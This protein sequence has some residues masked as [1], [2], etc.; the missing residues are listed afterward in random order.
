MAKD[1]ASRAHKKKR[2]QGGQKK[3]KKGGA[4]SSSPKQ[5]RGQTKSR[6]TQAQTKPFPW[7]AVFGLIIIIALLVG[8]VCYF[9]AHSRE[10]T[11]R[12]VPIETVQ[13]AHAARSAPEAA[14]LMNRAVDFVFQP[15][16]PAASAP[17]TMWM[18]QLG[19][20]NA[21]DD[22]LSALK[23]DLAQHDFHY[24]LIKFKRASFIQYRLQMGPYQQ[25]K[26]VQKMRKALYDQKIYAI[27]R[28]LG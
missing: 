1:Y 17:P 25:K 26:A 23:A 22:R 5:R 19:T 12:T 14:A 7:P 15:R 27:V 24:A 8:C 16:A 9:H 11:G 4:P 13:P 3:R 28:P 6:S 10:R 2:T 21:G 20:F 18:L